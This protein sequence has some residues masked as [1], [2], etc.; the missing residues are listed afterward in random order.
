MK[1]IWPVATARGSDVE[2]PYVQSLGGLQVSPA[3]DRPGRQGSTASLLVT[4]GFG[5]SGFGDG[6]KQ[7]SAVR[8]GGW[9]GIVFPSGQKI[10]PCSYMRVSKICLA[11]FHTCCP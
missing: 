5:P 4:G 10:L 3:L 6:P 2:H 11:T 1:N 9:L 8:P 7:L